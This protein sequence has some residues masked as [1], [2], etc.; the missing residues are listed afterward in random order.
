MS[1]ADYGNTIIY[2]ITC[3][4][5]E[6]KDLYVG[7]TTN[8]VQRKRA[9]KQCSKN[10]KTSTSCKLYD[11]IRQNGGW[12]NWIMEIIHFCKCNGLYE[13]RKKEQEFFV[14]L[15]ATLNSV[16][17][18]PPLK[19]KSLNVSDCKVNCLTQKSIE[20]KN[21]INKR[22]YCEKCDYSTSKKSS[23][24]THNLSTKHKQQHNE[25]EI[26]QQHICSICCKV[27]Q[28]RTGLWRHK[29]VCVTT[30]NTNTA[31]VEQLMKQ[32]D[33]FKNIIIEQNKI[34][35]EKNQ[36]IHFQNYELQKQTNELHKQNQELQKQILEICKNGIINNMI[37]NNNSNN[38]TFNLNLFLYEDCKDA[39]NLSEFLES[40]KIQLADVEA[41]GELGY[42]NGISKLII[43][44]LKGIDVTKRP[45]HCTDEKREII[46]IKEGGV[47]T[48][49]EDYSKLRRFIT[50]FNLS[51]ADFYNPEIAYGDCSD[52]KRQFIGYKVTVTKS[53][54][55]TPT[56]RCRRLKCEMV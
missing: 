28:N 6:I 24:D 3:K 13:A 12:D 49:D 21:I 43:Q 1:E 44:N 2:K 9:H 17:P 33:D 37:T 45:I 56:L 47:W 52:I 31:V 15:N 32:N 46:Y 53:H 22:F 54:Q 26:C 5:P 42:I 39:M 27:Y 51:I 14:S 50:P 18:M 19:E 55:N 38:K 41:V 7:H 16:E 29:K 20:S 30:N 23:F 11:C 10:P 48:K 25:T 40:I 36:E 4:D 35:V 34:F 8:F